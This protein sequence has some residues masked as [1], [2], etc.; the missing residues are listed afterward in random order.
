MVPVFKN[1]RERSAAKKLTP[2]WSVRLVT[3]LKN[4]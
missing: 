2:C 1:V 4:L 3:S